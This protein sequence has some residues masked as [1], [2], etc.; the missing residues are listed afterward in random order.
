CGVEGSVA[1]N[2]VEISGSIDG[3]SGSGHPNAAQ[4]PAGS[5][6]EGR[7]LRETGFVV[8]VDVS[9]VRAVVS[10]RSPCYIDGVAVQRKAG[11]LILDQR[12]RPG[13]ASGDGRG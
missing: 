13:A 3:W 4:A 6:V 11:P 5:V 2:A 9:V 12:K 8:G 7:Y 1:G 10:V